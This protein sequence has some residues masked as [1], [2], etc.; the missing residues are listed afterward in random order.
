MNNRKVRDAYPIRC[1][2]NSIKHTTS[3]G[4]RRF[5]N[6]IGNGISFLVFLIVKIVKKI[7]VCGTIIFGLATIFK[8]FS[9]GI[10]LDL[11]KTTSFLLLAGSLIIG[12]ITYIIEG[13]VC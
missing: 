13:I 10:S 4:V 2:I 7:C 9:M 11:F 8:A 5:G 12:A 6:D 1:K 3:F